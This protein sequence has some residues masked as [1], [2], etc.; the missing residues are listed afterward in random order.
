[1]RLQYLN[2]IFIDTENY[3]YEK[4]VALT[5]EALEREN[6]IIYEAAFMVDGYFIRTDILE[7]KRRYHPSDRGKSQVLIKQMNFWWKGLELKRNG[8]H[9]LAFQKKVA[10]WLSLTLIS[11]RFFTCWQ[12]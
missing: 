7:K 12:I 10:K 2:D 4:A 5:N 1:M 3:E 8:N 6:V 11:R 9:D